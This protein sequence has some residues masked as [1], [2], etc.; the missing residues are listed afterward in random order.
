MPAAAGPPPLPFA[1]TPIA[2][3]PATALVNRGRSKRVLVLGA[4][5]AGL[6]A[7]HRLHGGGHDVTVL[8]ARDRPGGRVETLRDPFPDG[9]HAEAGAVFVGSSHLL[10]MGYCK[11]FGVALTPLPNDTAISTA[12]ASSTEAWPRRPGRCP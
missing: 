12:L 9:L 7:A 11:R 3:M 4:G 5:L 2:V 1:P 8:E 10:V 6:S